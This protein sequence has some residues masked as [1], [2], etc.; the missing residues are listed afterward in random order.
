MAIERHSFLVETWH[1]APSILCWLENTA[2]A[3]GFDL[4][5]LLA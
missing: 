4:L 5:K 2:E 1:P 3:K